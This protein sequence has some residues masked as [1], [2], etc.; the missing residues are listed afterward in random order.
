MKNFY[1]ARDHK[2]M[3]DVA[4]D[5]KASGPELY[6][7][8]LRG[9]KE[10]TNITIWETGKVGLE[11]IKSYGHYHIGDISE[12]Y[13][14]LQG[15]GILLLQKR[16]TGA[17]GKPIDEEIDEFKAISVKAGDQIFIGP[18]MAHLLANTG[19]TWLVVSDDS[20][21]HGDDAD[22]IGKPGHADYKPVKKM[23]GFAYFVIEKDGVPTLVK[24][25]NYKSVPEATISSM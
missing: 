8:M 20:P 3:K 13:M 7:Y 23:G 12:T 4:M 18:Y 5:K 22:P 25:P 1:S 19:N 24:N 16:K 17:D 21:I 11:Y 15:A 9:G 2:S 10:K 6:Y 14:I